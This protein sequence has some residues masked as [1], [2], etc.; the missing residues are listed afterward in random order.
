MAPGNVESLDL[1]Q[2]SPRPWRY[3]MATRLPLWMVYFH[4]QIVFGN[5]DR[6]RETSDQSKCYAVISPNL[7]EA[8]RFPFLSD[9][10][11]IWVVYGK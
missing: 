2:P 3:V 8:E 1:E 5:A 10:A 6:Y 11:E 7:V 9:I 4:R